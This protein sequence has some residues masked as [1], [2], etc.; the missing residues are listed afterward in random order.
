MSGLSARTLAA[1]LF[2][3]RAAAGI[4]SNY[5]GNLMNFEDLHNYYER[6]VIQHIMETLVRP[7]ETPDRDFLEDVAC[8][9]LN[10]LPPR[11]I[12]HKVDLAFYMPVQERQEMLAAVQRAVEAAAKFVTQNRRD[13]RP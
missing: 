3:Q 12:R 11:Y 8:V 6:L 5:S 2:L 10:Q 7:D 9:A 13:N 4:G 1:K